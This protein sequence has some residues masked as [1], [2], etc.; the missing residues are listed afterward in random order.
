MFFPLLVACLRSMKDSLNRHLKKFTNQQH[1][2]LSQS[3]DRARATLRNGCLPCLATSST[4]MWSQPL[5]RTFSGYE[6]LHTLLYP[7]QDLKGCEFS[8]NILAKMAG[9]GMFLPVLGGPLWLTYFALYPMETRG[10]VMVG[11]R[12]LPTGTRIKPLWPCL[13][14]K[15][16]PWGPARFQTDWNPCS[17][18]FCWVDKIHIWLSHWGRYGNS[19]SIKF[20]LSKHSEAGCDCKI[21]SNSLPR[22][23][24]L[25]PLQLRIATKH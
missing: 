18:V 19:P 14:T 6:Q 3:L 25:T 22:D 17:V 5:G 1:F 7:F 12:C 8:N 9:N 20:G 23:S 16:L 13:D 11:R 15:R 2:D 4:H 21:F 10:L 24:G